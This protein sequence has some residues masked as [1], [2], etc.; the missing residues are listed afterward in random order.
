MLARLGVRGRLL[1]AFFGISA[2]AV[3]GAGAALYSFHAID[4][5][6]ALITQR[7]IPVAVKSQELSRHAERIVAAAPALLTTTSQAEKDDRSRV[8]ASEVRALT[9]LSADLS[10]A[11]V[12]HAAL[13]SLEPDVQRLRFNLRDLDILVN[14]RLELSTQKRELLR[15]AIQ[16]ASQVQGLLTPW[17]SVMDERIS[18]WRRLAQSPSIADKARA[19][20]DQEIEKSLAWSLALRAS[21]VL[22]SSISDLLQRAASADDVNA[23]GVSGFRLQQSIN[24]LERLAA[25]FDPKLR[26]LVLETLN[27][28]RPFV[29]GNDSIAALRRRELALTA[30]GTRLLAENTEVSK[31]LTEIM[32]RLVANASMDITEANADALSVVRFSTWALVIAVTLSLISSTLIVWL[33]VG[34]NIIAR[35]TALSNRMLTLASGDLKSPLPPGGLDEIGRMAESLAVFRATA[36]EMEEE[37]LREIREARTRLTDAIETISEGFSLYDADDKL[38]IFNSKYKNLFAAHADLI[39]PGTTFGTIVRTAVERGMIDDAEVSHE[40]WLAKRFVQHKA[41]SST[42][43]QHRSDGRWIQVSERKT[44]AGGLV[45]TYADITELKQREAELAAARDA[46]ETTLRDLRTAQDR[47]VQLSLIHI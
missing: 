15:N 36:I 32:E 37:N 46:A 33:Y 22:A 35:L 44:A 2:L 9:E 34:R 41:P 11:G 38:V 1:L 42:H 45:A 28:L 12:D 21:E 5:A 10:N 13:Q 14:D 19:A 40:T 25:Q 47:L 17:I 20:A 31:R 39:E 6:L 8:I 7:R 43:I 23:A 26:A 29:T 4:D 24:E 3:L 16:V 18:Q 27:Q 30:N